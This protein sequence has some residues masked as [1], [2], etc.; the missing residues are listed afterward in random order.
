MSF[1]ILE[2]FETKIHNLVES[3]G[4]QQLELDEL[5]E[6][7]QALEQDNASLVQ[8]RQQWQERLQNLLA[9]VEEV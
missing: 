6:Q 8:E 5:R 3:L 2:Q 4:M 1:E 9:K 7:K